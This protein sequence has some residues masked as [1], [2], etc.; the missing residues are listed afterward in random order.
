VFIPENYGFAFIEN[1]MIYEILNAHL[2]PIEFGDKLGRVRDY[3]R[4]SLMILLRWVNSL[5]QSDELEIIFR[6]RPSLDRARLARFMREYSLIKNPKLRIIKEETAR[7]WV[8]ASDVVMSSYSTVLIEAALAR[9][10]IRKVE[11]H[12]IPLELRYEWSDLVTSV[13]SEVEM[14][15]AVAPAAHD[16]GSA[17]LS[18]W[19]EKRFFVNGDPVAGLVDEIAR[20]TVAAYQERQFVRKGVYRQKMPPWMFV[21][22]R[23]VGTKARDKLYRKFIPDYT[24]QISDH[25]KDFFD[26]SEVKR[27]TNRWLKVTKR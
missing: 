6:P 15:D 22:D 8:I 13:T 25:E 12:P 9:K 23:Y 16:G 10:T 26:L 18:N 1:K 17:L 4:E 24:H 14:F 5:A 19:A 2:L 20:L 27:R 21:I 7:D 3:C 11:P